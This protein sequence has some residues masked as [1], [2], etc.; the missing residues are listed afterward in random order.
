MTI[1]CDDCGKE[2]NYIGKPEGVP[3]VE[4]MS[5]MSRPNECVVCVPCGDGVISCVC[6]N[7]LQNNIDAMTETVGASSPVAIEKSL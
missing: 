5:D 2:A 1:N 3:W 4:W 6:L 7:C